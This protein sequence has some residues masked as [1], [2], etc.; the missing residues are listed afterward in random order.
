[1]TKACEIDIV[2]NTNNRNSQITVGDSVTGSAEILVIE[3]SFSQGT[4][5]VPE[6]ESTEQSCQEN[7]R[8]NEKYLEFSAEYCSLDIAVPQIL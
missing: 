6:E 5:L 3:N 2:T 4:S 7:T 8:L 1:M